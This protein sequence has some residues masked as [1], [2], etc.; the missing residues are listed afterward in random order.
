MNAMITRGCR[1][2]GTVR[3]C[4]R[5]VSEGEG[6]WLNNCCENAPPVTTIYQRNERILGLRWAMLTVVAIALALSIAA[7]IATG[8]R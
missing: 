7:V 6:R 8:G 2:P 4:C 5:F 1:A 3:Q